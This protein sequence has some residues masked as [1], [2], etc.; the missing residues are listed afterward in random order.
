[1]NKLTNYYTFWSIIAVGYIAINLYTAAS[2]NR[3]ANSLN[4]ME[5]V[6]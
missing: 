3:V 4:N 1:M 6:K 5:C 2:Y